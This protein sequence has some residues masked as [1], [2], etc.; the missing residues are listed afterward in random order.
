MAVLKDKWRGTF[1]IIRRNRKNIIISL[2]IKIIVKYKC[3]F[4][5]FTNGG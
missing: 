1:G 3:H 5:K 2:I 4:I